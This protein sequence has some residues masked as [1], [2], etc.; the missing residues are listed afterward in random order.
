MIFI[1]LHSWPPTYL[2]PISKAFFLSLHESIS[3]IILH[4]S[5]RIVGVMFLISLYHGS[6]SFSPIKLY[7]DAFYE[8]LSPSSTYHK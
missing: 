3:M 1:K 8:N 4:I 7:D 5:I 6:I 2:F